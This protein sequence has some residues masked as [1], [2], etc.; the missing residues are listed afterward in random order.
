M[1]LRVTRHS[2]LSSLPPECSVLFE[3]AGQRNIFLTYEWFQNFE[4]SIIGP[5]KSTLVYIVENSESNWQPVGAL[6]LQK[7]AP[8]I[9]H[10]APSKLESM[11]NYYTCYYAPLFGSWEKDPSNSSSSKSIIQALT[12]ALLEDRRDWDSLDLHPLDQQAPAFELFVNELRRA[13]LFVQTYFCFGNW[14]LIL[15]GRCYDKYIE[16]LPSVLRKNIPYNSRRLQRMKGA[17][18]EIVKETSGLDRAIEDYERVYNASWKNREPFPLF[19]RGLVQIAA[20]RGWLRL[21]LIYV[22]DEPAAAQIWFVHGGTASIYK[23]AYD[24]R[25]AKLSVGTVL[26]SE[27]M[28]HVIDVDKVSQVDYL[29]GDDSYKSTWMSHRR[30]RWGLMA[31]NSRSAIGVLCA[32][33]HFGGRAIKRALHSFRRQNHVHS[34]P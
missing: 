1:S 8:K 2:S 31:F 30:E 21:G 34:K 26:T 11:A 19:I 16:D 25:F 13:G 4:R 10:L 6:I 5:D 15:N 7:Q 28:K 17:R 9:R 14:Y 29:S 32:C 18:I 23:I 3:Q 24:E 33:R 22:D 27:L 20:Q 12:T